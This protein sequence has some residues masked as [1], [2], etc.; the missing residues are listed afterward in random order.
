MMAIVPTTIGWFLI[1]VGY[2]KVQ[3]FTGRILTG[4][5]NGVVYLGQVYSTECIFVNHPHLQ[6]HVNTWYQLLFTFGEV[7]CYVLSASLPYQ[8]VALVTASIGVFISLSIF[9]FI[10]ESPKWLYQIGRLR[11]AR[12]S[13]KQLSIY[14]PLYA[15]TYYTDTYQMN[16]K[17]QNNIWGDFQR[18][19]EKNVYKPMFILTSWFSLIA[20]NGGAVLTTYMVYMLT[21]NNDQEQN[22]DAY[23]LSIISGICGLVATILMSCIIT[24]LGIKLLFI[25][26]SF[27]MSLSLAAYAISEFPIKNWQKILKI[28]HVISVWIMMFFY[29]LGTIKLAFSV[30]GDMCPH[31]FKGLACIPT[32]VFNLMKAVAVKLHLYLYEYYENN[33]Y[34]GYAIIN[35]ISILFTAIFIPETMRKT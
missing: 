25:S 26:S 32:I 17:R 6:D 12:H 28:I 10:P 35:L 29:S 19:R 7:F 31:N 1:G 16:I 20:F 34:F 22:F 30:I 8:Q 33:V 11:E 18:F 9:W 2:T 5:A 13:E 14:Q 3:I 15:R 27:F 4:V 21:D 24:C 23:Q